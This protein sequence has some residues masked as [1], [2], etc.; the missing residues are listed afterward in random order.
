[1]PPAA[2]R[3]FP[4]APRRTVRELSVAVGNS[5]RQH[6]KG[7]GLV[8]L[9]TATAMLAVVVFVGQA[10]TG[11]ELDR[12]QSAARRS[13]CS[14]GLQPPS[15]NSPHSNL[16]KPAAMKA[17]GCDTIQPRE[18]RCADKCNEE[19][20]MADGAIRVGGGSAPSC[21]NSPIT[22]VHLDGGVYG[23]AAANA[24]TVNTPSTLVALVF[25]GLLGL[26]GYHLK[27]RCR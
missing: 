10:A 22:L 1:M 26:F 17:A 4:C 5:R 27:R 15:H 11:D 12:L 6:Q 24:A 13:A 3:C 18:A 8:K 19:Q 21:D 16:P 9:I 20:S 14:P 7:G 23:A 2:R 25:T